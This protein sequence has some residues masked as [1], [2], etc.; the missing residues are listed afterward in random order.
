MFLLD[1]VVDRDDKKCRLF[2][3]IVDVVV[4]SLGFDPL[5]PRTKMGDE[6]A[7]SDRGICCDKMMRGHSDA[8]KELDTRVTAA[9]SRGPYDRNIFSPFAEINSPLNRSVAVPFFKP[10][11]DNPFPPPPASYV[12]QGFGM[13]LHLHSPPRTDAPPR[14]GKDTSPPLIGQ[15]YMQNLFVK[16]RVQAVVFLQFQ[17]D[18]FW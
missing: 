3:A 6:L 11:A 9:A 14:Q 16:K 15:T 8:I 7:T 13:F 10:H 4:A 17:P 5:S 18:F 1:W 12:V 2:F